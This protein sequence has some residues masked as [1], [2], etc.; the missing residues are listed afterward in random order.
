MPP[1]RE[2]HQ[3]VATVL[4]SGADYLEG[5]GVEQPRLACELLAGR[6]LS[7]K[8]LDLHLKHDEPVTDV[9]Q[10]AMRRG[11]K[12]VGNGEPVQYV[13]GNTEFMGHRFAVDARALI[14][15]PETEGLLQR[16]LDTAELW[17]HDHPVIADVGTGSGC[18]A[19]SLLL[20]RP[21]AVCLA[22]DVSAAALELARENAARHG[23]ETRL[24]FLQGELSDTVDPETVH[25][26][27]ANPPYIPSKTCD[28]LPVHIR[29]HEPRQALDGGPDGVAVL[30]SIIQ[31]AIFVLKPGGHLFLEIGSDQATLVTSRLNEE[32]YLDIRVTQDLAGHDRVVSASI[33]SDM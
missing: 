24:S 2:G 20:A 23:V 30:Q 22:L 26:L 25:A 14:P 11:L 28:T 12:R 33:P 13:T 1:N 5:K 32:G 19:I 27:V 4:S 15:R 21:S 7:C 16:V 9:H 31:D 3:T 8:R 17:K 29:D 6:L 18:I 10:A